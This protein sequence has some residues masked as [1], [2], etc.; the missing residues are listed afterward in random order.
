M[1]QLNT[2]SAYGVCKNYLW[3]YYI[4]W[5]LYIGCIFVVA[6]INLVMKYALLGTSSS[7]NHSPQQVRK[8][9][10]KDEG[11][12][13]GDEEAVRIN[14]D[15][16]DPLDLDDQLELP[17][18]LL[19]PIHPGERSSRSLRL[20]RPLQRFHQEMASQSRRHHYNFD[21]RDGVLATDQRLVVLGSVALLPSGLLH[22][23]N[24]LAI[25][26]QQVLRRLRV[27]SLGS[28]RLHPHRHLFCDNVF[29]GSAAADA[30][31]SAVLSRDLLDR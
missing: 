26:P 15:Q 13:V 29:A 9:R 11:G 2:N 6:A 5:I 16:H 14:G 21:D 3:D 23:L 8:V 1:Y 17:R 7:P 4:Y 27:H 25:R 28:L 18:L 10:N 22:R 12:D 24:R 30:T 20:P 19:L 31:G